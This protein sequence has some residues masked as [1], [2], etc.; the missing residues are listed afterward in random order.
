MQSPT[1]KYV[2]VSCPIGF[3][4]VMQ[5]QA[6]IV[7]SAFA[8]PS[9]RSFSLNGLTTKPRL[10]LLCAVITAVLGDVDYITGYEQTFLLFYLVPIGIGT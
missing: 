10:I 3:N 9:V 4:G 6:Y 8:F 5:T 2:N 1:Q 7:P